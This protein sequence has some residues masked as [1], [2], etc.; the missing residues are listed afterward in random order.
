MRKG[1]IISYNRAKRVGYIKDLNGQKIRFYNESK[2]DLKRNDLVDYSTKIND[3]VLLAIEIKVI[4]VN[5]DDS[6]VSLTKLKN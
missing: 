2:I 6:I 3:G 4:K 1:I 5:I